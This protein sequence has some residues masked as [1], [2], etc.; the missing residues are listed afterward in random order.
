MIL[1]EYKTARL[2]PRAAKNADRSMSIPTY[3]SDL[4]LEAFRLSRVN[5]VSERT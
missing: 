1:M 2:V 3:L 4:V 5:T